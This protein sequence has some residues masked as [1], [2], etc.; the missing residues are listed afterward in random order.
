MSVVVVKPVREI[1][2]TVTVARHVKKT[3]LMI[4]MPVRDP[5]SDA[6]T[7]LTCTR[8]VGIRDLDHILVHPL[9]PPTSQLGP[10]ATTRRRTEALAH[11]R[12]RL[13]CFAFIYPHDRLFRL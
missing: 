5:F 10:H 7:G 6:H 9:L 4:S 8:A 11:G 1:D 13:A 12:S 2:R 3:L